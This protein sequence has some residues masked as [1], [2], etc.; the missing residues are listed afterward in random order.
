MRTQE[1]AE[2]GWK[3][4]CQRVQEFCQGA[5]VTIELQQ[6][7]GTTATIARDLPLRGIAIDDQSD[8][9]NTNLIIEA[10]PER[11]VRHIVV[12]PIHLR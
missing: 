2:T 1:I 10:G 8:P 9:C 11:P 5:M 3:Q 4:F 6:P 7:E 12:E